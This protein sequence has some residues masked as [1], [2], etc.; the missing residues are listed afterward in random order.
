MYTKQDLYLY[1][2]GYEY[3][4][5]AIEADR[6]LDVELSY[7]TYDNAFCVPNII[8]REKSLGGGV[9]DKN[10]KFI[11]GTSL[12]RGDGA[13][14]MYDFDEM[15]VKTIDGPA[16]YM[17]YFID[18]WGHVITDDIKRFWFLLSDDYKNIFSKYK[19]IYLPS[20][21]YS[22]HSISQI[23]ELME[24]FGI[25]D[26]MIPIQEVTKIKKLI[27]PNESFWSTEN[28]RFF[29]KEYKET[30]D[31]IINSVDEPSDKSV[32]DKI[33]LSYKSKK[34]FGNDDIE[35]YFSSQG[36]VPISPGNLSL[37]RQIWLYQNC[38]TIAGLIGSSTHNIAFVKDG[39]NAILIPRSYYLTDYQIALNRLRN[40]REFYVDS[41]LSN[42]VLRQYP[43]AGP[44]YIYIS[45]ELK[46]LFSDK[47]TYSYNYIKKCYLEYIDYYS[48]CR[49]RHR[50]HDNDA[51][52]Y[53]QDNVEKRVEHWKN[54]LGLPN[55]YI[56]LYNKYC[57]FKNSIILSPKAMKKIF[58]LL[59]SKLPILKN[60]Q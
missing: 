17:G 35:N 21:S 55:S 42:C 24:V 36:F 31:Y 23:N 2:G 34:I 6:L 45:D 5:E 52:K 53:Y 1:D 33:Y 30:I 11:E 51:P 41:S 14:C 16:I 10:K 54:I 20:A 56:F 13:F 60:S 57:C 27:I 15:N 19:L 25:A 58:K 28:G 40:V 48:Y 29:T 26:R 47:S 37:S 3:F 50:L 49:I 44:F 43:W 8:K 12:H 38:N 9:I 32:Y 7:D 46:K 4:K 22:T 18:V 39:T 59:I